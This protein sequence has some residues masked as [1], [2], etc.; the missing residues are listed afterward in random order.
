MGRQSV[1]T[2]SFLQYRTLFFLSPSVPDPLYPSLV[3]M[4]LILLS[5][6]YAHVASDV[7]LNFLLPSVPFP[8]PS[9]TANAY[10]LHRYLSA[11][12][13]RTGRRCTVVLK[14]ILENPSMIPCLC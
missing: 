1:M 7:H 10:F 5:S 3:L 14:V 12:I 9:L 4:A 11:D 13:L 2:L 6:C 8:Q